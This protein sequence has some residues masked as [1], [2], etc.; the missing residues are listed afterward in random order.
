MQFQ[1]L[2]PSKIRDL[3]P[4]VLDEHGALKVMPASFYGTTTLHERAMLGT[5][6][7]AYLLPTAEL[8]QWLT[9]A[10]ADV[11]AIEIGAG[12]GVLAKAS[13]IKGTDNFLQVRPDVRSYYESLRQPIIPYDPGLERLDAEQAV[14]RLQPQTVVA[15]WVT[16]VFDE[17]RAGAGGN[18]Y[19]VD[20]NWIL[21][22]CETYIFIGNEKVH[23]E[24]PIWAR[25]HKKFYPAWLYSRAHN[26]SPE[27]IAIW[28]KLPPVLPQ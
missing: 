28:G 25:Q 15:S 14:R 27:F 26:G 17:N 13:G 6:I 8:V 9:A 7:G 24:K 12:N 23:R 19:G 5:L 18:M 1:T 16:H 4:L 11:Q 10:T 2:D 20:E 22:N 21:D 3:R